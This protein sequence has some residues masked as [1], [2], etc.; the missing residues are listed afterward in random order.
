M[1]RAVAIYVEGDHGLREALCLWES[2]AH[3][4]DG[5][6]LVAFG[7]ASVLARLPPAVV[8]VAQAPHADHP[9]FPQ[10]TYRYVNSIA[11]LNGPGSECLAEYDVVL[12][13]DADTFLLPAW[14]PWA[15]RDVRVGRCPYTLPGT[16]DVLAAWAAALGLRAGASTDYG[17]SYCGPTP[18]VRAVA[19]LQTE[20]V[21]WSLRGP[22]ARDDP[23]APVR[24]GLA[25]MYAGH[26]A[27][28]HLEPLT[29]PS[30][31][32]D[33]HSDA[34][35]A[36]RSAVHVHCWANSTA[37]FSKVQFPIGAYS[38]LDPA[39]LDLDVVRDYCTAMALRAWRRDPTIA[40]ATSPFP[41]GSVRS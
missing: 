32:L 7:P 25:T 39:T 21:A 26:L 2:V 15:P 33:G 14:S 4:H 30:D 20:L 19:A 37:R 17:S 27:L 23:G 18:R 38:D 34:A 13:T 31:V 35:T 24:R 16:Q 29:V 10:A 40:A 9:D 28:A 22:L 11:C 1:R 8:R 36:A 5:T 41:P 3:L 12:R 6:D